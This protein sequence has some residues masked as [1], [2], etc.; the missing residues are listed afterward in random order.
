[1]PVFLNDMFTASNFALEMGSH[2]IGL[3]RSGWVEV[4]KEIG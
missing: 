2:L 3:I 1:M 4:W